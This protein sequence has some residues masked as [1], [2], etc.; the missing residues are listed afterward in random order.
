VTKFTVS[1]NH[2]ISSQRRTIIIITDHTCRKNSDS[3]SFES[4]QCSVYSVHI[5]NYNRYLSI[6]FDITDYLN[7]TFSIDGHLNALSVAPHATF[8]PFRKGCR[9]S[10]LQYVHYAGGRA[11]H[12]ACNDAL[13]ATD[14]K[15]HCVCSRI[16]AAVFCLQCTVVC[17]CIRLSLSIISASRSRNCFDTYGLMGRCGRRLSTSL[18]FY[19]PR[20]TARRAYCIAAAIT[21]D[22]L[23]AAPLSNR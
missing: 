4:V 12:A 13:M 7:D 8:A 1:V 16:D 3:L 9:N 20:T 19:G 10:T 5:T 23:R 6:I 17:M 21:H 2:V 11:L 18:Y 14:G 22:S 15:F